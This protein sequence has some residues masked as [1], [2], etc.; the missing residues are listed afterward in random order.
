MADTISVT[1]VLSFSGSLGWNMRIL[2]SRLRRAILTGKGDGRSYR[3]Q[4]S[5]A[6]GGYG[7]IFTL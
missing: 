2:R 6:G 4:I 3:L 7:V 1:E 5:T